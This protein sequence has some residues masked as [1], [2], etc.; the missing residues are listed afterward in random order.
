MAGFDFDKPE[1]YAFGMGMLDGGA[2][3]ECFNRAM[4]DINKFF[5]KE[6]VYENVYINGEVKTKQVDTIV[7]LRAD[8]LRENGI[9]LPEEFDNLEERESLNHIKEMSLQLAIHRIDVASELMSKLLERHINNKEESKQL[10][11]N[12]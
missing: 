2:A 12:I 1:H 6:P 7:I 10:I 11:L 3:L 5:H 4:F 8:K 9:L